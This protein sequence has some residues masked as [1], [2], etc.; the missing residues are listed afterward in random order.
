MASPG[1]HSPDSSAWTINDLIC[2]YNGLKE[3]AFEAMFAIS[4]QKR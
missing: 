1:R 4:A 2:R 3:G